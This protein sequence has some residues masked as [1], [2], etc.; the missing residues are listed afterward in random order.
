MAEH[1]STHARLH[2]ALLL[3]VLGTAD[4]HKV[5]DAP[6]PPLE[7]ARL[8]TERAVPDAINAMI[9]AGWVAPSLAQPAGAP[10]PDGAF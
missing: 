9:L 6:M 3:A 8:I 1:D 10:E 5:D 2:A 7:V 4:M